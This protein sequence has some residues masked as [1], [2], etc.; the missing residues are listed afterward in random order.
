MSFSVSS[1][2]DPFAT[3]VAAQTHQRATERERPHDDPKHRH[4]RQHDAKA[5]PSE[6]L[7]DLSPDSD[8]PLPMGTLIDVRA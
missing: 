3:P 5:P 4:H 8:S 2:F 7:A 1:V 6:T